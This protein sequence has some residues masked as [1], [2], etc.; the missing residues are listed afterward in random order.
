MLL[1]YPSSTNSLYILILG[2]LVLVVSL[3][4]YFSGFWLK[5][6]KGGDSVIN[7]YALKMEHVEW[8]NFSNNVCL[9]FIVTTGGIFIN[10]YSTSDATSLFTSYIDHIL[11]IYVTFLTPIIWL[12][13]PIHATMYQIRKEITKINGDEDDF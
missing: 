7:T 2:L 9:V 3:N 8:S 12:L 13:R 11:I 10:Y 1:L 5:R 6:I 4:I